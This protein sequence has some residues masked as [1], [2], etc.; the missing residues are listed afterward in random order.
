MNDAYFGA[1]RAGEEAAIATMIDFFG[2][3]G[4][5]AGWPQRVRDY[6]VETTAVNLLDW[7]SAFGFALTPASLAAVK[8]PTLVV[9]GGASHPAVQRANELLGGWIPGATVMAIPGAAHFMISTHA[10]EMARVIA[11]HVARAERTRGSAA[12]ARR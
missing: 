7:A 5:F 6:A 1:F 2:G 11:A 3:A 10:K 12:E 8:V 4:T 9:R